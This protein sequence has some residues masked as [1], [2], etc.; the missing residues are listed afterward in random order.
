MDG[1]P[2]RSC[3]AATYALSTPRT[4]PGTHR[5]WVTPPCTWAFLSNL[6]EKEF[7]R[8]LLSRAPTRATT[9]L[10]VFQRFFGTLRA[11]DGFG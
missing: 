10:A 4:S 3:G 11:S 1:C 2:A 7:L 9:E 8:S 6:G 5:R